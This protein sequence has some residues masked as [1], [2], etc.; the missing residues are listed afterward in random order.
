[1]K[2]TSLVLCALLL[3][4][5]CQKE[6]SVSYQKEIQPIL[7]RHCVSCHSGQRPSGKIDLTSYTNLMTTRAKIS[8]KQ[9]LVVP[10]SPTESRLYVLCATSQVHFRMPP[11]TSQVTPLP[12]EELKILMRWIN[13][14]AKEN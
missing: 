2:S 1:M 14:G 9:P 13:Q 10:G 11:D 3:F 5:G 8:G 4:V 12:T 7:D 6:E